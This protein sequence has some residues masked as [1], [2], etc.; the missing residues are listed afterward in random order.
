MLCTTL[1]PSSE[2][3]GQ[4]HSQALQTHSVCCGCW[5]WTGLALQRSLF[6]DSLVLCMLKVIFDVR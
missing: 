2:A 6:V 4:E 5:C 1:P 3:S